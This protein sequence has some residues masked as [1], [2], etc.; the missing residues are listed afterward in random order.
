MDLC[1]AQKLNVLGVAIANAIS[2]D[3][4]ADE[5][6]LWGSLFS[7]IGDAL[8]VLAASQV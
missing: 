1:C 5:L 6:A 4:P 3:L 7:V 8:Q 2:E